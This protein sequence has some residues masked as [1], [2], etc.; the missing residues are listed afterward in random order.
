MNQAH[1]HL[2]FNHLPIIF[3]IAATFVLVA[4]MVLRLEVVKRTAFALFVLGALF[5]IPAGATGEGAEELI[6]EMA[7][8]SHDLIHEHEEMAEKFA[9]ASYALGL[10][11]A[12]AFWASFKKKPFAGIMGIIVLIMG[13][14]TLFLASKT[15]T[16]GGEIRH[17]EIRSQ[18]TT[19]AS[20]SSEKD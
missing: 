19:D 15:G 8:V 7:G 17:P 2:L 4:G 6:E 12:L 5:T 13:L 11:G 20:N 9:F 18:Q 14:G 16:S 10:L 1:L 3:P